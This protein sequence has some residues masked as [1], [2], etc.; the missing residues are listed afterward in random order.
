MATPLAATVPGLAQTRLSPA[1]GGPTAKVE[2][3]IL[4]DGTWLAE[5][6]KREEDEPPTFEFVGTLESI[7]PWRAGGIAFVVESWTEVEEGLAVGDRVQVE[8]QIREDGTW[9]AFEV[10]RVSEKYRLRFVFFGGVEEIDPWVVGGVAIVVDGETAIA[11][12]VGVGSF[13][14]V[15]LELLPDGTWRTV[16]IVPVEGPGWGMGCIVMTG[17][18]VSFEGNELQLEGWP[19]LVLDEDVEIEGEL[20]PGSVVRFQICFAEDMSFKVIYVV[21]V[22]EPEPPEPPTPPAPPPGPPPDEGDVVTVC[23]KPGGKNPHTLTIPR[24]A[25]PA[26]L[27]HG[28]TLGSCP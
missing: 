17:M 22:E 15:E 13:V 23:H 11:P 1:S 12:D 16:S 26:H 3:W 21:V 14:R 6:I 2:G 25:L 8:G 10:K 28:D 27:G 5:E 24:S 18:V 19:L 4:E 9:V 20:E 7:D